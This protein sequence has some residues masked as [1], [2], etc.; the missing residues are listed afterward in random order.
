GASWRHPFGP[1]S[2]IDDRLDHPVVQVSFEDASA[3]AEWAGKR[4]PTEPEWEFA[5]RGGL[6]QAMYTWGNE[7]DTGT[8]LGNHWQGAFPY[9]NTGA[10]GWVGTSPVGT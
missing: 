8:P 5:A 9:L 3:Y 1:D 10:A 6:D 2:G 4:L 7:P